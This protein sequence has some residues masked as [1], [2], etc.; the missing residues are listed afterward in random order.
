MII[1]VHTHI[2]EYLKHWSPLQA[3]ETISRHPEMLQGR[4]FTPELGKKLF[5]VDWEVFIKEMDEA[6]VDKAVVLAMD[7]SHVSGTRIP[8]DYVYEFVSKHPDRLIGFSGGCPVDAQGRFDK[9][10][11]K[12]F[13]KAI[14]EYGFKGLKLLP[15]EQ[16]F[17][18]HD[19]AVYPFYEKAEE[20]DCAIM[21]HQGA[22]PH[23]YT[24]LKYARPAFLQDVANDFPNLRICV[25]HMGYPWTEE[26]LALMR[27]HTN[28]Y[29]D[30]SGMCARPYI[31]TWDL[32]MAKEY[33]VLNRVMWGTDYPTCR[34]PKKFVQWVREGL[35]AV[36]EK[37]GW[38]TFSQEEINGLLGNN[39]RNYLKI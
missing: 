24:L 36:A 6:G 26:L 39:A 34:P 17:Y 15:P 16:H 5:S 19:K 13:E 30:I 29:A 2:G 37:A 38:P 3:Q 33:G 9:K 31:M 7:V 22:A 20:L 18:P 14:T 27:A 4:E 8:D 25:A 1:D 11:L 21:F 28:V 10:A 35:N 23:T 32:V 12:E